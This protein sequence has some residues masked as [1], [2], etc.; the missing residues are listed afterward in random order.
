MKRTLDQVYEDTKALTERVQSSRRRADILQIM[1]GAYINS[2]MGELVRIEHM[3]SKL[4]PVTIPAPK[5]PH[6]PKTVKLGPNEEASGMPDPKIY[7]YF[8]NFNSPLNQLPLQFSKSYPL[9]NN[10]GAYSKN[11]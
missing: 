5:T 9:Y 3:L 8:T 4:P 6:V 10:F 11:T 2:N 7:N 1:Q